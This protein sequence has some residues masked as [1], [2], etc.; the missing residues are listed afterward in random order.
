MGLVLYDLHSTTSQ[1]AVSLP[2]QVTR[3]HK[4][5]WAS[6]GEGFCYATLIMSD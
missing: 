5:I 6:W 4:S 2:I 1:I 3:C